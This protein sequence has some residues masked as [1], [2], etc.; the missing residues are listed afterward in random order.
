MASSYRSS[1]SARLFNRIM[2]RLIRLGIP[3]GP[4]GL[5]T[6]AGRRSGQP[7]TTP[8]F[9][10]VTDGQRWII[11]SWGESDWVRNVRAAGAVTIR[12]GRHATR[13]RAEEQPPA[14]TVAQIRESF[15]KTPGFLRGG[16]AVKPGASEA[17][18][19]HEAIRHPVFF[20]RD[21]RPV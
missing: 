9:V 19:A 17:E 8:V 7:R 4:M 1:R 20:L 15:H 2:V 5:L 21:P 11:S 10:G 16:Y 3:V 14:K 18:F 12:Q 13:Y 6:V